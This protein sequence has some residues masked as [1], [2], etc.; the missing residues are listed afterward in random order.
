M[1][2]LKEDGVGKEREIEEDKSLSPLHRQLEQFSELVL[3][4]ILDVIKARS[5]RKSSQSAIS[6]KQSIATDTA[7]QYDS[8][9]DKE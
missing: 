1:R 4:F 5:A 2:V 8:D 9:Q 3:L 6:P 7:F